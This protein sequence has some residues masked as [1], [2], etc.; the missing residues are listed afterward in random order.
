MEISFITQRLKKLFGSEE[1][2]RRKYGTLN[3]GKIMLR[4]AF[5][6][7]AETLSKVPTRPP[8]RRHQLSGDRDEQFAVDLAHPYRLV[9][10]PN[11]C[12]LPRREDGG[13]DLDRVTAI[14]VIEVI[15][16]H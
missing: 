14:T 5:L 4:M 7:N 11:H 3:A 13:I 16:Y 9:F 10:E 2:L 6:K 1:S 15:D 12:P 8:N